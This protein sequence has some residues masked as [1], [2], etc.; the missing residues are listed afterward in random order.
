M[1]ARFFRGENG[2]EVVEEEIPMRLLE[3]A[4]IRRE[5]MIDVA[6]MFS[7]DLA[8]AFLEGTE[9]EELIMD[10]VRIATIS[11]QM[12]PVFIGSAF[13]NKGVQLLLDAVVKYLPNPT[14]SENVARDRDNEMKELHLESDPNKPLVA[15]AFK[16]ENQ[17]YGQL[18]YLR[19]YQGTLKKGDDIINARNSRKI[20]VGR[21]AKMHAKNMEDINLALAGDIVAIFGV[22]CALGDTFTS[23]D[24]NYTMRKTF[25]P[26]PIIS[27]ALKA[28][29][30]KSQNNLS[31][32]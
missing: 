29:D 19:I 32:A 31:K 9:T 7:D 10:A 6:S 3:K 27:L 14:E 17:Q 26:E 28:D 4:K 13:K 24:V 11:R 25:I 16:L 1:K 20:K 8:E 2:E 23:R 22:D 30:N 18:T 15:L 5:Q 21:L 12:T